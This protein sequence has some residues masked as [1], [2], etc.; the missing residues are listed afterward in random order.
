MPREPP[1]KFQVYNLRET[2][3]ELGEYEF[4]IVLHPR[5]FKN[6]HLSELVLVDSDGKEMK[7]ETKKWGRKINCHFVIDPSVA[8][9]V[10]ICTLQLKDDKERLVPGRLTFWVIKP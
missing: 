10:S 2:Y 7:H 1:K 8:D 4:K 6:S 3:H 5:F 9:G